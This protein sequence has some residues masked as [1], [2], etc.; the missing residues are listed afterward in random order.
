VTKKGK[1]M[2]ATAS[3]RELSRGKGR[4]VGRTRKS[5]RIQKDAETRAFVNVVK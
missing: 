3:L 5:R 1:K 2:E 4:I